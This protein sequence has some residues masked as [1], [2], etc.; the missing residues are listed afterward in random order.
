M[1][2]FQKDINPVGMLQLVHHKLS[3]AALE[4]KPQPQGSPTY[5]R[6]PSG[7]DINKE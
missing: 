1:H 5:H 4:R 3:Q 7:Q 6:Y 2:G